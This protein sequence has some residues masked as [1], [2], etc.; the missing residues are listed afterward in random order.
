MSFYRFANN[1]LSEKMWIQGIKRSIF[2]L[3]G[4]V[5]VA[6]AYA[7]D[8]KIFAEN[9]HCVAYRTLKEMF[10]F[11][12]VEVIGKSC[13]MTTKLEQNSVN[14]TV[15]VTVTIPISTLK[16]DSED[17]DEEILTIMNTAKFPNIEFT[18]V[19][20]AR[21][22]L[23]RY[24]SERKTKLQ[25]KL[26]IKGKSHQVAFPLQF[27]PQSKEWIIE[28]RLITTF[29][30]FEVVVPAVAGGM[31]AQPSDL[32]ELWL[33]LSASKIEGGIELLQEIGEW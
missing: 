8:L 27:R 10:L 15:R 16:S 29:S 31:I 13:Q 33:H 28:G 11:A 12:E 18:S 25:G 24:L 9:E 32:L 14:R 2:I 20:F 6:S 17:R 21:E 5:F 26:K 19:W 30:A 7:Q 3:L 1:E 23:S 4:G 22:E